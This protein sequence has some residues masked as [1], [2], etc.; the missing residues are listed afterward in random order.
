[1]LIIF[2]RSFMLDVWQGSNVTKCYQDVFW[3]YTSI[4]KTKK[5]DSI[6]VR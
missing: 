5:V 3:T 2:A 1:M 6:T 4:A